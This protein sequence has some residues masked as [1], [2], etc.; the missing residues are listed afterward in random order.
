[1]GHGA[2]EAVD[3]ILRLLLSVA[4]ADGDIDPD[5][6]A[7]VRREFAALRGTSIADAELRAIA[8]WMMRRGGLRDCLAEIP[9]LDQPAIERVFAAAFE[10]ASADGFVLEEEDTVLAQVA[11]ALR[12]SEAQYRGAISA[13]L[14]AG[15][16]SPTTPER[17]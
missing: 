2:P 12:M 1:M 6:L 9:P 5:E 14:R 11:A 15:A 8:E 16:E 17:P 13:L 10:V 4:I 3:P 7:V